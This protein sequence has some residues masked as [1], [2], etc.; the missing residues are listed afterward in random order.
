VLGDVAMAKVTVETPT[1]RGNKAAHPQGTSPMARDAEKDNELDVESLVIEIDDEED[2]S[3]EKDDQDSIARAISSAWK[4]LFVSASGTK[5]SRPNKAWPPI[6][7]KDTPTQDAGASRGATFAA[8]TV[9]HEHSSTPADGNKTTSKTN[10]CVV[11][12]RFKL[13][14][15]NVQETLVGLLAHCLSVLEEWDK[16]ACVLNRRKT[17]EARRVSDLP[18]DFTNFYDEWGL[19]EEDIC[20]FLNTIKNKGQCTFQASFY[21]RCSGDPDALFTKTLLKM[22]KQSQH[23]GTVSIERKPC[24][25]LDTTRDII[26]FNLPFCDAVGLRDYLKRREK[27]PY[28]PVPKQVPLEGLGSSFPRFCNGE[29]LH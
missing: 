24:Q 12:M 9:F 4:E 20:M 22:A 6:T 14:P 5:S 8:K 27:P 19:W 15:C 25:H 17:L 18:R 23:K 28:P 13:Q 7:S 10:D 2:A 16:S 26:F 21:F 11:R 1:D 3:A 29:G